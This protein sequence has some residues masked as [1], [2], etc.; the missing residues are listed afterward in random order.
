MGS[1]VERALASDPD[2][3]LAFRAD[4][5]LPRGPDSGPDLSSLDRGAVAGI[6]D[7]T[8]PAGAAEAAV[9][10]ERIGCALVSGSTG[11]DDDARAALQK[12]ARSVAVCW[13]PNFSVGIPLLTRAL[14]EAARKLP[15]GWQIEIAEVHHGGKRDAPSGTALRLAETWK[16]QRGGRIVHGRE[17]MVGPR[18]ADEIGVHAL[19]IGDVVGEHRVLLGVPGETIEAIHRAQD[20]TAFA[21]GCTEALRRLLR[22]GP[23]WYGWEELLCG[24]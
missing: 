7:F 21:A 12:A 11:L 17:G 14:R 4:R 20:R 5:S 15:D 6:I 23:G 18:G 1:A 2:L 19:R 9:H 3:R 24:D 10:A 22:Q 13:S 16:E 8:S